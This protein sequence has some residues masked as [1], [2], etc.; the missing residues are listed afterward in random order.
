[1][2]QLITDPNHWQSQIQKLRAAYNK[3]LEKAKPQVKPKQNPNL[4]HVQSDSLRRRALHLAAQ[5]TRRRVV[6]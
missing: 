5:N 4:N 2:E 1:M 6:L 3:A